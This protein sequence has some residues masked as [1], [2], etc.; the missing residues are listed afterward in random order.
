MVE[1]IKKLSVN[2][3]E[4]LTNPLLLIGDT[5]ISLS[6]LFQLGIYLIIVLLLGRLFKNLL[7]K[8]L[9]HFPRVMRYT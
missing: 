2:L 3:A 7:K 8:V 1:I 5:Y 4:M 6:L 9:Q